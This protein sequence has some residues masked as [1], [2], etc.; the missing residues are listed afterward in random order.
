MPLQSPTIVFQRHTAG[1]HTRW[2]GQGTLCG[3]PSPF[4][5]LSGASGPY[6]FQ[7]F[8]PARS[9]VIV[10]SCLLPYPDR[11]LYSQPAQDGWNFIPLD[12]LTGSGR[13]DFLR[14]CPASC[15]VCLPSSD[16][17]FSCSAHHAGSALA[18]T[19]VV[20]L[21]L[22]DLFFRRPCLSLSGELLLLQRRLL[23]HQLLL[24]PTAYEAELAN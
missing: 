24:G 1:S 18:L 7:L 10:K 3:E 2:R 17:F 14:V 8:C 15:S 12:R 9:D 20:F 19:T 13:P 4:F 23:S 6:P 11:K 21:T 22:C 5:F 16:F